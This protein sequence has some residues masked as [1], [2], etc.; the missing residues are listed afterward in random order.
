[1][2]LRVNVVTMITCFVLFFIQLLKLTNNTLVSAAWD[3][4]VRVWDVE[5]GSQIHSLRGHTEGKTA[6]IPYL[7]ATVRKRSKQ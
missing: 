2:L 4:S 5:S 7:I 1:M 6:S 3:E